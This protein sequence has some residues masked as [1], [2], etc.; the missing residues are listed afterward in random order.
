MTAKPITLDELIQEI[1]RMLDEGLAEQ[2]AAEGFETSQLA[3]PRQQPLATPVP[4]PV[5]IA[6]EK[7]GVT[8]HSNMGDDYVVKHGLYSQQAAHDCGERFVR[9]GYAAYERHMAEQRANHDAVRWRDGY[10]AAQ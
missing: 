2:Q 5:V 9:E 6:Q 10:D 8:I 1:Q 7:W 4:A 3:Q